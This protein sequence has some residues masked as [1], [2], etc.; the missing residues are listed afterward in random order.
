MN[1][2]SVDKKTLLLLGGLLLLC[3]AFLALAFSLLYQPKPSS[4]QAGNPPSEQSDSGFFSTLFSSTASVVS[5]SPPAETVLTPG[6]PIHITVVFNKP[7]RLD[8]ISVVLTQKLIQTDETTRVNITQDTTS[9]DKQLVITT[10]TP[11]KPY[12]TYTF[13]ISDKSSKKTLLSA[14]YSSDSAQPSPVQSNNPDLQQYLPYETGTYA[15]SYLP[16][17][18]IYV[19]NFLFNPDDPTDIQT[20]FETAKQ[21]ALLF[22][23]SK[24]I[25]P[26]SLLIDWRFH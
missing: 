4:R 5:F 15:L 23:K 11:I 7:V 1:I 2:S 20:Q 9:S 12:A 22:I 13:S 24:G 8:T 21:N 25:D 14:V 3:L 26:N 19:F 10:K 18:N 6:N 17:Q 16:K